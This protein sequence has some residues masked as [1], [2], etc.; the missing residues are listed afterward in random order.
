MTTNE[1]IDLAAR[2][3]CLVQFGSE[4]EHGNA[5][6][7]QAGGT[8]GCCVD[9]L[10]V[11]ASAALSAAAGHDTLCGEYHKQRSIV[12]QMAEEMIH[13]KDK[14]IQE[15]LEANNAYLTRARNAEEIIRKWCNQ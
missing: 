10:K 5:R 4:F 8:E 6:C 1:Q 2:A 7:C 12:L 15:L 11:A 9:G 3:I 14:R 13:A